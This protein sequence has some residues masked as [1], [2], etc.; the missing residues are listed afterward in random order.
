MLVFPG[1]AKSSPVR[2]EDPDAGSGTEQIGD[3]RG[4][5]EDALVIVQN[6]QQATLA[7]GRLKVGDERFIA[8]IARR[9]RERRRAQR[10]RDARLTRG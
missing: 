7:Y 3:E 5:V 4:G 2:D 8:R 9:G 6:E 1:E 10:D